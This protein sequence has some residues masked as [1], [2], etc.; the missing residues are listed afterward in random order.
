MPVYY[1]CYYDCYYDEDPAR[2][3][4]SYVDHIALLAYMLFQ[5]FRERLLKH[6]SSPAFLH[7]TL[8]IWKSWLVESFNALGTDE[9]HLRLSRVFLRFEK[10][11][12]MHDDTYYHIVVALLNLIFVLS[13]CS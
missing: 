11:V 4:T 13:I 12:K 6:M 7:S 5:Q 3:Q 8:D 2:Q 10:Y 9:I 1:D